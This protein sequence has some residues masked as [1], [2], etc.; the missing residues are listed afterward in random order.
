MNFKRLTGAILII[1]LALVMSSSSA[2]AD[3][4]TDVVVT[5]NPIA[6]Y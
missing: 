3:D 2:F 6:S 1:V 4:K 5:E